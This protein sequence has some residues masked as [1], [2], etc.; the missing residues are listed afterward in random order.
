[1]SWQTEM[2]TILRHLI[3]DVDETNYKYNDDRLASTLLVAARLMFLNVD[4]AQTYAIDVSAITITPDPTS[5][6]TPDDSFIILTCLRASCIIL[7]SEIKAESGNAISIKDGPSAIDLRGVTQTL[8]MLYKD[9][10]SKYDKL[11][12]QYRAGNSLGGAAIL[13]PYSPGSFGVHYDD[14]RNGGY[15]SNYPY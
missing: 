12:L 1:M 13:G 15:F 11:L 8:T 3:N 7:S 9:L 6:I 4:F 10:S 14:H 5:L 2:V